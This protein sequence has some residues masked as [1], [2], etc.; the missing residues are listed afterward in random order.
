MK[1]LRQIVLV[2]LCIM[3]AG[4]SVFSAAAE[5]DSFPAPLWVSEQTN[6]DGSKSVIISTPTYML[7]IVQYYEYSTDGGLTWNT[8]TDRTGGEFVITDTC[9]FSLRYMSDGVLSEVYSIS[10]V[11]NKM[12]AI[13]SDST[14]ITMIIPRDS[15]MPTDV[16]LSAYEI[17]N[18]YDYTAVGEKIGKNK[19]YLLFSV[20]I[21]R[22]N[23]VFT[24]DIPVSW[25]FPIRDFDHRYCKLYHVSNNG[26]LTLIES[27]PEMKMLICTMA[28]TGLFAVVED[29]TNCPGDVNGDAL[30]TAADARLTLRASAQLETLNEI[31]MLSADI[32]GNGIVSSA[33]AR[34]I[35]RISAGLEK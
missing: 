9:E 16:T 19:P 11:V 10:V 35:L 24:S 22:N 32:D 7:D 34:R 5:E 25:L 21:M 27:A 12:T 30:V 14:K 6:A 20:T 17:V 33:D 2:L 26:T 8:L 15:A 3:L 23:R 4:G 31:Q 18:G 1:K 28:E 29:K 13:T